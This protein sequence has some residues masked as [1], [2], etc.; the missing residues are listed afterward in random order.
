MTA[1]TFVYNGTFSNEMVNWDKSLKYN[2]EYD[3]ADFYINFNKPVENFDSKFSPSKDS[4]S[5][6]LVIVKTYHLK[7][8]RSMGDV[9]I[10]VHDKK[11][12]IENIL[13]AEYKL[14]KLDDI[15]RIS[16][17]ALK[18]YLKDKNTTTFLNIMLQNKIYSTSGNGLNFNHLSKY[19]SIIVKGNGAEIVGPHEEKKAYCGVKLGKEELD[20]VLENLTVKGFNHG[21][22]IDE[23]TCTLLNVKIIDNKCKYKN[24]EGKNKDW[25]A[26]ILN[27]GTCI[28]EN[29]TFIDNY[30]RKGGAIFNG[31]L[32]CIDNMSFFAN[33]TGFKVGND[34]L[35]VDSAITLFNGTQYKGN[36]AHLN[37]TNGTIKLDYKKGL[38]TGKELVKVIAITC[39]VSFG[40][41]FLAGQF[42]S[43]GVGALVG[44]ILGLVIGCISALIVQSHNYDYHYKFWKMTLIIVSGSIVAGIAGGV[45]GSLTNS[46][47]KS[48]KSVPNPAAAEA[49]VE[50]VVPLGG[51][52]PLPIEA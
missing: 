23:G 40:I 45:L 10:A 22:F 51:E 3:G 12:L 32:L 48:C 14:Q 24:D 9:F 36:S 26:G 49:G 43:I 15:D 20:V 27:L 21:I 1:D 19:T 29:C 46:L 44:G 7:N 18:K 5:S 42:F 16:Y 47:F 35:Y 31:G 34:I 11:Y 2:V 33:N 41:N 38:S 8:I 52:V 50:G 25:G 28:V 30:A 39:S 17:D 37:F 13:A 4:N 6:F